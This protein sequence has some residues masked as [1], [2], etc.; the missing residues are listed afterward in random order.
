MRR[1]PALP[2]IHELNDRARDIAQH[3]EPDAADVLDLTLLIVEVVIE[4]S[5]PSATILMPSP[6]WPLPMM[7]KFDSVRVPTLTPGPAMIS[8]TG[9]PPVTCDMILAPPRSMP[10]GPW[11]EPVRLMTIGVVTV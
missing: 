11:L 9:L 8:M 5:A 4:R 7:L 2:C 1:R 6:S 3:V 10:I